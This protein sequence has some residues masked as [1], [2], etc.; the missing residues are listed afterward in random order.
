LKE[1]SSVQQLANVQPSQLHGDVVWKI[2]QLSNQLGEDG[3]H[4]LKTQ[5]FPAHSLWTLAVTGATQ[6]SAIRSLE[7]LEKRAAAAE[8][9][10]AH[11][12]S[13]RNEKQKLQKESEAEVEVHCKQVRFPFNVSRW[14]L[15]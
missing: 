4:E 15:V 13:S 11:L 6:C 9:T 8:E 5:N 12:I 1:P 10:F 7:P 3:A 14:L 2:I